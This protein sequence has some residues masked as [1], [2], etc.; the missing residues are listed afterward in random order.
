MK[1]EDTKG[2]FKKTR[3][4]V[5]ESEEWKEENRKRKKL[6]KL[7]FMKLQEEEMKERIQKEEKVHQS[8]IQ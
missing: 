7:Y 6:Q 4:Q 2:M 8:I 5:F 1:K 3:E